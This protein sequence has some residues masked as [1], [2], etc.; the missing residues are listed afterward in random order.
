MV[1]VAS[2]SSCQLHVL[3]HDGHSLG[4]DGADSSILQDADKV[5][6]GRLLESKKGLGLEAEIVIDSSANISDQSLERSSWNEEV[7]RLLVSLDLSEG[8]GARLESHLLSLSLGDLRRALG[9]GGRL[10]LLRG[11]LLGGDGARL[12]LR[13][14]LLGSVFG[15]GHVSKG[16]LN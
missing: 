1:V 16:L 2:E 13:W 9:L 4:V 10:G 3:L 6:L 8:N 12:G 14:D 11:G 15:L 5:G 7:S